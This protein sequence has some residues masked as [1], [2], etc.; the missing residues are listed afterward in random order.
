[1]GNKSDCVSFHL[2]TSDAINIAVRCK[3]SGLEISKQTPGSDGLLFTELDQP[4]AQP[5]LDTKE[6]D[7]LSNI[8]QAVDEA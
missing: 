8:M 1:V 2:R 4:N 5:C 3:P 6:F 7:L